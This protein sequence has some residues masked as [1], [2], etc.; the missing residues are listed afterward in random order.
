MNYKTFRFPIDDPNSSM[1]T[2][3]KTHPRSDSS[4][5]FARDINS[6]QI[7]GIFESDNKIPLNAEEFTFQDLIIPTEKIAFRVTMIDFHNNEVVVVPETAG[8]SILLEQSLA[9]APTMQVLTYDLN[10]SES[11]FSVVYFVLRVGN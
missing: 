5:R 2:K 11:E 6:H 1:F 4:I 7:I 9:S 8:M 10:G 3:L